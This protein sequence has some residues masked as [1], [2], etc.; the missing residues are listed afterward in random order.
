MKLL[1]RSHLSAAL[2]SLSLFPLRQQDVF[3]SFVNFTF[4]VEGDEAVAQ[5][6]LLHRF[7]QDHLLGKDDHIDV[8]KLTKALQDLSHGLGF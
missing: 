5:R 7:F 1:N 4:G 8:V 2:I 6:P 3:N